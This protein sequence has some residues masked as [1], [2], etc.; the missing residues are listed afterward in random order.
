MDMYL[1]RVFRRL[2]EQDKKLL[3]K[4]IAGVTLLAVAFAFYLVKEFS[5]NQDL[6][7]TVTSENGAESSLKAGGTAAGADFETSSV[8]EAGGGRLTTA[9]AVDEEIMIMVDVAGAVTNPTVVELPEGSRVFEAIEKAGGLTKDADT[10]PINRAELLTDGQKIYIP[11]KQEIKES[12]NGQPSAAAQYSTGTYN[13]GG[14]QSKPININTADSAT[15]QQ[16]SGVG[17]ATA[18]KIIDYRNNNGKFK[19]IEDIK[20]V[21]GIGEKT[22]EKFKDKI[23]I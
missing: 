21:S 7:V 17:P 2:I 4:V 5:A 12:Q 11:T 3:I 15:L 8:T 16:L 23:T 13:T 6:D 9:G 14:S 22:Y 19:T 1:S 10:G 20:N 18:E